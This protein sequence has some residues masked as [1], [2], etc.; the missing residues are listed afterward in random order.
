MK[1]VCL[2]TAP[3]LI[4]I[5]ERFLQCDSFTKKKQKKKN[6][7][8]IPKRGLLQLNKQYGDIRRITKIYHYRSK[9]TN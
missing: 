5:Q 7:L 1:K 2:P 3:L 8:E 6:P 9:D 4:F